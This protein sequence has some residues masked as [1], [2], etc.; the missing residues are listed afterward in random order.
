[1]IDKGEALKDACDMVIADP[2]LE[3]KRVDGVLVTHCN[4][5]AEMVAEA[6]GCTDLSGYDADEQY[7]IL[8][9]DTSG[10]W[11]KVE[12]SEATIHALDGGLGFAAMPSHRLGEKHGHIAA[13][14]P[15]GMQASGSLGKDVPMVA[16][17]GKQDREEKVSEAFP[18]KMGEPDYFIWN[19]EGPWN[20]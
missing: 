15:A 9:A 1:M 5:G 6:M 13:I 10:R 8:S 12:G 3:T 18:V 2:E 16:N 4:Q 14:Y 7:Q 19:S 11:K 20:I 17:V